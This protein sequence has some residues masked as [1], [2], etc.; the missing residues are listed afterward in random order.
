M[1]RN[2]TGFVTVRGRVL[3]FHKCGTGEIMKIFI[4]MIYAILVSVN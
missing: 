3:I 4:S 1:A 2:A